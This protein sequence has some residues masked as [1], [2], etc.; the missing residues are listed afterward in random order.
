MAKAIFCC[1]EGQRQHLCHR[2]KSKRR[3]SRN[4]RS[5]RVEVQP[6]KLWRW[7]CYCNFLQSRQNLERCATDLSPSSRSRS[8]C[9]QQ[10]RCCKFKSI[11]SWS[12]LLMLIFIAAYL[13]GRHEH[14][15]R[16]RASRSRLSREKRS[17]LQELPKKNPKHFSKNLLCKLDWWQ[18]WG[19][20]WLFWCI[21]LRLIWH[22][23]HP[24]YWIRKLC[25]QEWMRSP[26]TFSFH[27]RRALY[28]LDSN[29]HQERFWSEVQRLWI[30]L[31]FR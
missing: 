11:Y 13:I 18:P 31:Q 24:R 7:S 29:D 15:R 20:Q 3:T 1:L 25:P 10:R 22:M 27:Q 2:W 12:A 26:K 4:H 5:P 21:F 19:G 6:W 8:N 23:V 9:C 14:N 28:W 30:G 16:N 17:L